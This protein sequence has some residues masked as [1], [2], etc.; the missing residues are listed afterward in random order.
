M[1]AIM[2]GIDAYPVFDEG[3]GRAAEIDACPMSPLSRALFF[4]DAPVFV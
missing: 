3:M 1:A 2:R 4:V